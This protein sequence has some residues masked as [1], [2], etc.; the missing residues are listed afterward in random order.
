MYVKERDRERERRGG[1]KGKKR[2]REERDSRYDNK[3]LHP[4]HV[5]FYSLILSL[6]LS[7]V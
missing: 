3:G 1:K 7:Q 2:E 4:W 6:P 5:H